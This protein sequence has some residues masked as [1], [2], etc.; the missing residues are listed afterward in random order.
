M[1]VFTA[2]ISVT[3][4]PNTAMVQEAQQD[5]A[6]SYVYS[7]TVGQADL[8]RVSAITS[9]PAST[10]MVVT[11]A[12]CQKSDAGTRTLSVQLKS[13]STTVSSTPATALNTVWGWISRVD[14]TDP[15][16][17]AAWTP[18]AVN[19]AQIGVVVVA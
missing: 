11:R 19:N 7:S 3:G 8:Y 9:T 15:A 16:T 1:P 2:N 10:V 6:T 5:A 12:Y 17:G 13:G 14:A 4:N 18:T